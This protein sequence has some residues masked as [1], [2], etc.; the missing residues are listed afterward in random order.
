[1][2]D[3]FTP[4][5]G[6][7][8]PEVGASRDTWGTKWN[9]NA[10]ILDQFVSRA[11]PIGAILDFAGPNAPSGWL[12]ADGRTV[13]RTTYSALFAVLG[14]YWGAGDGSTTFNLPGT[15]GRAL[16]GPGTGTDANGT[17]YSYSFTQK[18]GA[19]SNVIAKVNL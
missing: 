16:I 17:G 1:M 14:T 10:T 9:Q 8:Q 5:L 7:T 11:M 3:T 12:I 2:P 4:N 19:V 13:S 18:T 6:L 15:N